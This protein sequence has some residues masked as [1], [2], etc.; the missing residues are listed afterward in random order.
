MKMVSVVTGLKLIEEKGYNPG[1]VDNIRKYESEFKTV[2]DHS[3]HTTAY[4]FEIINGE[5]KSYPLVLLGYGGA[6]LLTETSVITR[7][8]RLYVAIDDFVVALELN[9]L[10][11]L[12]ATKVDFSTCFGIF[13]VENIS[14]IISWG[15]VNVSRLDPDGKIQWS[16]SGKDIFSEEFK[17][18]DEYAFATDFEKNQYKIDLISGKIDM[19]ETIK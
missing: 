17:I 3:K 5:I 15:E 11:I 2:S 19:V 14:G 1:S 6:S 13:W 16:V 9:S 4:G 10:K 18:E 8:S 12:W 7:N